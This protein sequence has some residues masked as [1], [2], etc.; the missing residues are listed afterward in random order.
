LN[1]NSGFIVDSLKAITEQY[2]ILPKLF[3]R[4]VEYLQ[5]GGSLAGFK[6][7]MEAQAEEIL[8]TSTAHYT[9]FDT[10]VK[11]DGETV[12][13]TEPPENLIFMT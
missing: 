12:R 9:H 1:R 13:L 8:I 10:I 7:F 6:E 2:V 5:G 4:L 11:V 3:R